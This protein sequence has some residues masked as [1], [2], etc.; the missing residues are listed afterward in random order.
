MKPF[1]LY[2]GETECSVI[3]TDQTKSPTKSALKSK[4][5]LTLRAGPIFKSKVQQT[6]NIVKM[7]DVSGGQI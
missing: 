6:L 4:L 7:I 5:S 2:L 3:V 1:N